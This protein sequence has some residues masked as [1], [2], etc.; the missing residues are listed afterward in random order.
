MSLNR[1]LSR[2]ITKVSLQK[3]KQMSRSFNNLVSNGE[4]VASKPFDPDLFSKYAINKRLKD[5]DTSEF[6]KRSGCYLIHQEINNKHYYKFGFTGDNG[7]DRLAHYSGE[8]TLLAFFDTTDE[9]LNKGYSEWDVPVHD[10]LVNTYGMKETPG[11][12]WKS[13]T[14]S[15]ALPSYERD[16]ALVLSYTNKSVFQYRYNSVLEDNRCVTHI[17]RKGSQDKCIEKAKKVFVQGIKNFLIAAKCRFGKTETVYRIAKELGLKNILVLTYKKNDVIHEWGQQLLTNTEFN[18]S[19]F[20]T[21]DHLESY[22]YNH[23]SVNNDSDGLQVYFA[24]YQSFITKNVIDDNG[25]LNLSDSFVDFIFHTDWDM[26]VADEYHFGANKDNGTKIL[27][28]LAS[29]NTFIAYLSGTAYYELSG[30]NKD[31]NR[32][33]TFC[34]SYMEEQRLKNL[35]LETF[36]KDYASYKDMAKIHLC[37]IELT[38]MFSKESQAP[39][40]P[41]HFFEVDKEYDEV[42]RCYKPK[43][44]GEKGDEHYK[45]KN[46]SYIKKFL[47]ILF[48]DIGWKE[49]DEFDINLSIYNNFEYDDKTVELKHGVWRFNER[50]QVE[51]MYYLLKQMSIEQEVFCLT[52]CGHVEITPVSKIHDKIVGG[53]IKKSLSLTVFAGL[54]GASV[55]EWDHS[56]VL[57]GTNNDEDTTSSPFTYVQ[58]AFRNQTPL[59]G[60]KDV[61][62][63]DFNPN[64]VFTMA[65]FWCEKEIEADDSEK[66]PHEL[67]EEFFKLMPIISYKDGAGFGIMDVADIMKKMDDILDFE[68]MFNDLLPYINFE[69]T[70]NLTKGASKTVKVGDGNNMPKGDGDE[71][72]NTPTHNSSREP[73]GE[74]SGSSNETLDDSTDITPTSADSKKLEKQRK[75]FLNDLYSCAYVAKVFCEFEE[76]QFNSDEYLEL[77]NK[78]DF[79]YAVNQY[80]RDVGED[81]VKEFFNFIK[82]TFENK[83]AKIMFDNRIY[84]FSRKKLK[85]LNKTCIGKN[86]YVISDEIFNSLFLPRLI[87]YLGK[88][89]GK[90]FIDVASTDGNL[91]ANVIKHGVDPKDCYAVCM[92]SWLYKCTVTRLRELGVPENNIC[93]GSIYKGKININKDWY[94]ENEEGDLYGNVCTTFKN[95]KVDGIIMNPPYDSNLHLKILENAIELLKDENSICVNLSPSRALQDPLAKYKQGSDYIK[96]EKGVFKHMKN[97][98]VIKM[99]DACK[100]FNAKMTVDLGIMVFTTDFFDFYKVFN[101]NAIIDKVVSK[102]FTVLGSKL[103]ENLSDGW[104]V[105]VSKLRPVNNTDGRTLTN[106]SNKS[107][108]FDTTNFV[109]SWVY[110]DGFTK[111]G[112]HW[113]QNKLEG[114]GGKAYEDSVPI[115]M[116][117]AFPNET[118]AVNFEN[119]TKTTFHRYLVLTMKTDQNFP[120][121]YVPFLS[122]VDNPRTHKMG[123]ESDWT[124]EDLCKVF[125]ITGFISDTKAEPGSEWETILETMKPYL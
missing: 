46:E 89:N 67:R 92:N 24:S 2:T 39:F 11:V 21:E 55:P 82:K 61:Y 42:E 57:G 77:L 35:Y 13:D 33:N 90:T 76:K 23:W 87:G 20:Y 37:P 3:A 60:K 30:R 34:F 1:K 100:M 15:L 5:L 16:D 62:I 8:A 17:P 101:T 45:F 96:F 121:N 102:K 111:D 103:E 125:G 43:L 41:T 122:E 53:N 64:R 51:A 58:A 40:D 19:R 18:N 27:S 66:N 109:L 59:D 22:G 110:K 25:N 115:P 54:T 98:N 73:T 85:E 63:F 4:V 69:Y 105:R 88:L 83:D 44:F 116:S 97:M 12:L 108:M 78:K 120:M 84:C 113:S 70:L 26:I 31:L 36:N 75:K 99:G 80:L 38:K 114:A 118:E 91:I 79:A 52:G 106:N 72:K 56:L 28:Y 123:Y 119:S 124:N 7:N 49:N 50:A 14:E 95:L 93:I 10:R 74:E 65:N 107:F 9:D 94:L 71:V 68:N 29:E 104:R 6:T 81:K 86:S 47:K 48:N 112:K 32:D 117:I